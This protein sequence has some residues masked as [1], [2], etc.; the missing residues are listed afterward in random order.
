MK[1]LP[2]TADQRYAC[3]LRLDKLPSGYRIDTVDLLS[4]LLLLRGA[5][6]EAVLPEM[7]VQTM[8]DALGS[9]GRYETMIEGPEIEEIQLHRHTTWQQ[10]WAFHEAI[11]DILSAPR[12][13]RAYLTLLK[14][15]N[16]E[17]FAAL[18][19]FS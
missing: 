7:D 8:R 19:E 16:M 2:D 17:R 14:A 4:V 15:K 3:V 10:A 18:E 5:I 11:L 12:T 13:R 9:A 6:P 1:E